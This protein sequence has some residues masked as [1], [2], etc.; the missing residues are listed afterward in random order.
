[1]KK[2][3]I[4]EAQYNAIYEM[5]NEEKAGEQFTAEPESSNKVGE[6]A[7]ALSSHGLG[8]VTMS[9]GTADDVTKG[10]SIVSSG[11]I[12]EESYIVTKKQIKESRRKYLQENSN[13]YGLNDFIKQLKK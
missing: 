12:T 11:S 1:M 2:I 8:N 7:K 4:S 6:T 9:L 10:N 13:V 3:K 5:V